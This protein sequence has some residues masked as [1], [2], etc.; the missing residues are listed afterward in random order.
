M[1]IRNKERLFRFLF[2]IW[3]SIIIIISS[4]PGLSTPK[5]NI[6]KFEFRLD[7][8]FHFFIYLIFSIIF[9]LWK[10]NGK[11]QRKFNLLSIMIILSV[12]LAVFDEFHQMLIPGRTFNPV[13]LIFNC[14]GL[15]TGFIFSIILFRK[16]NALRSFYK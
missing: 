10:I 11:K 1:R 3:L 15:F 13:D 6:I 2:W 8:V 4:I 9:F 5:I 7:Y 14:A 12:I 16:K